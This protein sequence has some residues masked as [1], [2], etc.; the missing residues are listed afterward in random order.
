[1]GWSYFSGT[2]ILI[3]PDAAVYTNL[4]SGHGEGLNNPIL[5][6]VP[7]VGPIPAGSWTIGTAFHSPQTGPMSIPLTPQ[8]LVHG[9]TGF[10]IHGDEIAHAGEHLASHGCIIAPLAIR[11]LICASPDKLLVVLKS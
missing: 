8:D 3:G 1:M 2:G 5:E 9:R 7:D 10:F 6:A 4:Y 11:E